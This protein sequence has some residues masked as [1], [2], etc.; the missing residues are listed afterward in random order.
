M[1]TGSR[2]SPLVFDWEVAGRELGGRL[3]RSHAIV[4]LGNDGDDTARVAI[5]IARQ[6]ARR[7]RVVIADLLGDAPALTSLIP[8]GDAHGLADVFEY[9]LALDRIAR[10]VPDEPDMYVLPTGTFITDYAEIMANRRWSKLANSFKDEGGLLIVVADIGT[11]G[12]EG[13]VLQLEGAVLVGDMAPARLPAA[14]VLG[15]I[16]G[17]HAEPLPLKPLEPK[18]RPKYVVQGERSFWKAGAWFGATLTVLIAVLGL[19]MAYRPF[20]KSD[21]APMWLRHPPGTPADSVLEVIRGF[22]TAGVLTDS[23][24]TLA[25]AR[26]LGL[27]T[28]MDSAAVAPYGIV[29]ITFNTHA[30]ALLELTRNGA[31]LRAGTFTPILIRETPWFRVVAGAYPDS[32]SAAALLDTLRARGSSDAGRAVIERFPYALLVERDVPD[33]AVASRVSVYRTRGLPVYALLQ[34]D[35][36]ARLFAGAFKD[37]EEATLLYDALKTSGIQT[38]LVYRTGR[39]Y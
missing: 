38:S 18:A 33:S 4:V 16:R 21:W 14:R 22:D 10:R 17:L 24:S 29:I 36:T 31:T 23:T 30:G 19:W 15:A 13:L 1:T 2:S 8:V 26:G 27:L 20:A 35:G 34:T 12:I 32:A 6:Q 5:G 37:P 25:T 3:D 28:A 11:S 39:V 7:R 9:G